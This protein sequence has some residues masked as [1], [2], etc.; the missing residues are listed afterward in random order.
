MNKKRIR[1]IKL[2]KVNKSN[3]IPRG[4]MK[5]KIFKKIKKSLKTV[6]RNKKRRKM[7]NKTNHNI[8]IIQ[9]HKN[10]SLIY[11]ILLRMHYRVLPEASDIHNI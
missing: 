1:W 11:R 6:K 8:T 3:K 9:G 10:R 5:L 7:N 2:K 4:M